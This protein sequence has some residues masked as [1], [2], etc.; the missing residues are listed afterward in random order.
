MRRRS[1]TARFPVTR[2][3]RQSGSR[4][5]LP[6]T[7]EVSWM[8][9]SIAGGVRLDGA[10]VL[11]TVC[12]YAV[13]PA[14]A[15]PAPPADRIP[16]SPVTLVVRVYDG[17]GLATRDLNEATRVAS[18]ILRAGRV[19]V[20]WKS[21]PRTAAGPDRSDCRRPLASNEAV[22]R[23]I[24][25]ATSM[26]REPASLGFTLL[27]AGG[28]RAVLSTVFMDRVADVA[29]RARVDEPQLTGRAMAHELGHLLLGTS[30]HAPAGL[31][32]AFWSDDTL[33]SRTDT[34][35]QLLPAEVEAIRAGQQPSAET[36]D[37][38]GGS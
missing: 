7:F 33:R 15:S 17:V 4:H 3:R 8:T 26:T 31:M 1:T 36:F 30:G 18:D 29:R 9:R 12:L 32:R 11:A 27:D 35:W 23:L 24:P 22:L 13:S 14:A 19:D 28:R 25:A 37:A 21:C 16:A 34:D 38:V 6:F 5:S 2:S 10:L 20:R